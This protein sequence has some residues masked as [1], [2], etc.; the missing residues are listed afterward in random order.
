VR[1]TTKTTFIPRGGGPDGQ[2]PLLIRKGL[3]IAFSPYHMHRSKEIYGEDANEFRPERWEGAELKGIGFGFM[4][5]HGGPRICLGSRSIKALFE[6]CTRVISPGFANDLLP[7]EDFALTEASYTIV[8]VLQTFPIL[9]LPPDIPIEPSGVE[10]QIFT[11][12]VAS[13]EGC[14]VLL[15]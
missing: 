5:F 11:I 9:R 1:E 12:V 6:L 2:S 8:R 15:D 13:A 10:K 3:G 7:L 4:P 14:K